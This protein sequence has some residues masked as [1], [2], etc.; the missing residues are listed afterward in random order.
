ML[1]HYENLLSEWNKQIEDVIEETPDSRWE[2]N[3]AGPHT[4]LEYWRTRNQR[5]TSIAE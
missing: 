5:L 1:T 4:E 2:S 3:D